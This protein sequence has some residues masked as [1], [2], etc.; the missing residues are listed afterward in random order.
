MFDLVHKKRMNKVI[1]ITYKIKKD[2]CVKTKEINND[3]LC[4]YERVH[5][6]V[7][8]KHTLGFTEKVSA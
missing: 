8:S 4:I 5:V 3:E 7:S 2:R 6:Q 1:N